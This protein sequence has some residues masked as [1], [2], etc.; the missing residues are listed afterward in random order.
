M[1]IASMN[2]QGLPDSLFC[3]MSIFFYF[4]MGQHY[5]QLG[6]GP[7]VLVSHYFHIQG[8]TI[9]I[10]L[11]FCFKYREI[12]IGPSSKGPFSWPSRDFAVDELAKCRHLCQRNDPRMKLPHQESDRN[13]F[14]SFHFRGLAWVTHSMGLP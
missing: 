10:H 1:A 6:I 11:H 5:S 7:Q 8:T 4:G 9:S 14:S 3:M 12:R 13:V 2:Q